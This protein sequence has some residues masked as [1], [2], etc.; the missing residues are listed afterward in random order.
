MSKKNRE[1]SLNPVFSINRFGDVR[2][3]LESESDLMEM[4]HNFHDR[5]EN[6][7]KRSTTSVQKVASV[8][9][10]LKIGAE[11][12]EGGRIGVEG[13]KLKTNY[14]RGGLMWQGRCATLTPPMLGREIEEELVAEN[15]ATTLP[16]V[17]LNEGTGGL[18]MYVDDD[19]MEDIDKETGDRDDTVIDSCMN[20]STKG[21]TL[22]KGEGDL[23]EHDEEVVGK[24]VVDDGD[25]DKNRK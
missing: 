5:N 19:G 12:I 24:K 13:G 8:I 16:T 4:E 15:Q 21:I 23:S 7:R 10:A 20:F 18:N 22:T 14:G 6:V 2:L 1:G 3:G 9:L 11:V 17:R 25:S